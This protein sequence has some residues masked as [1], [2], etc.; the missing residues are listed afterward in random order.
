MPIRSYPRIQRVT[1]LLACD[2]HGGLLA[3][4]VTPTEVALWDLTTGVPIRS[5]RHP[6]TVRRAC[7]SPDGRRLAT[8]GYDLIFV[9]EVATAQLVETIE[10]KA[11]IRAITWEANRPV[12]AEAMEHRSPDG[13]YIIEDLSRRGAQRCELRVLDTITGTT[14]STLRHDTV[15]VAAAWLPDGRIVTASAAQNLYLWQGEK[16]VG[17]LSESYDLLAHACYSPDGNTV[18]TACGDGTVCLWTTDGALVRRFRSTDGYC[19]AYS[20]SPDSTRLLFQTEDSVRIHDAST[21]QLLRVLG[22]RPGLVFTDWHPSGRQ[23]ATSGEG[24]T[25]EIWDVATASIL[26]GLTAP[27]LAAESI[28]QI[29]FSPDGSR[30]AANAAVP[31]PTNDG[32]LRECVVVWNLSFGS[33]DAES[34]VG[35]VFYG[36]QHGFGNNAWSSTGDH[37]LMQDSEDTISIW[38]A[39]AGVLVS[40]E[41]AP[42]PRIT[43]Q[44]NVVRLW[45]DGEQVG[46]EVEGLPEG[47]LVIWRDGTLIGASPGAA[48]WLGHPAMVAGE[49]LRL[50]VSPSELPVFDTW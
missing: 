11:P 18:M 37:I 12:V 3:V 13:R 6:T 8:A 45:E 47:E 31:D 48:P 21:G 23:I 22:P 10:P 9:W 35:T 2:P 25:I 33:P 32:F 24:E 16:Q 43:I 40:R 19:V 5:M 1:E 46:F 42:S 36:E 4:G 30:L 20:W 14:L 41:P 28:A 50:P 29:A 15:V 34:T 39:D 26:R 44:D 7:F 38:D 27:E 49:L 17:A